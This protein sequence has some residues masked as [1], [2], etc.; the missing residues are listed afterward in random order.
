MSYDRDWARFRTSFFWASGDHNPTNGTANGFDGII[1]SP[2]FA[3]GEFSYWQTQQIKLF[4]VNLKNANSLLPSL[5]SDKFEGQANFNNPGLLLFNLGFDA[6]LTPKLKWINNVNW[7]WFESTKVLQTYTFDGALH[8]DIGTDISSGFEYR[9]FDSQ[10]VV[11]LFGVSTLIPSEGF[12]ALY[13]IQKGST[14][15]LVAG[16]VQLNLVY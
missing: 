10:N 7:L 8:T 12:K 15:P 13:D 2:N 5:N 6:E 9:P 14:P 1:D 3:G 16:F 11:V 4:G